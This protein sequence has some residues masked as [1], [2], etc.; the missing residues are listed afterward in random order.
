LAAGEVLGVESSSEVAI[1][2]R[3][4]IARHRWSIVQ[5]LVA[6]A[7]TA[8]LEDPFKGSLM[9]GAPDCSGSIEALNHLAPAFPIPSP[10][11]A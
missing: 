7:S 1:N 5:V 4:R 11:T 9:F 2:A 8:L 10:G 3:P 6:P